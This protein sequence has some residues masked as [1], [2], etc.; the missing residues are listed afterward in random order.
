MYFFMV[1]IFKKKTLSCC[2]C[3]YNDACAIVF[4]SFIANAIEIGH[5]LK[6]TKY[7]CSNYK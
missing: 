7:Q 5:M 3:H 2:Q 1:K 6:K 4:Y